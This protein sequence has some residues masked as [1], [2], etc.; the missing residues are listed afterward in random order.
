[1]ALASIQHKSLTHRINQST[2]NERDLRQQQVLQQQD[3]AVQRKLSGLEAEQTQLDMRAPAKGWI[4]QLAPDLHEGRWVS[5]DELL[6]LVAT[7][8]RMMVK[9]YIAQEDVA[10]LSQSSSGTFIPDDI[11]RPTFGVRLA[12]IAKTNS[13]ILDQPELASVYGGDI[14]VQLDESQQLIP[15]RSRYLAELSLAPST[16]DGVSQLNGAGVYALQTVNG[17]IK[18]DGEA[19]SLLIGMVRQAASVIMAELGF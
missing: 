13:T 8:D 9:A 19:E 11:S 2:V 4:M 7:S 17:V 18:L 6:A 15:K 5:K 10:R 16:D 12:R 1:M 14:A 3:L